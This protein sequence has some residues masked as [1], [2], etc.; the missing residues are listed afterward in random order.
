MVIL[1]AIALLFISTACN[2]EE[3]LPEPLV[4][5]VSPTVTRI[6]TFT[7]TP[8]FTTTPLPTITPTPHPFISYTMEALST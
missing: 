3:E 7:P 2:R 6:P 1:I 8:K 5:R 4:L